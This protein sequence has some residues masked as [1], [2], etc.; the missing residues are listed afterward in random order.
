[1]LPE[2]ELPAQRASQPLRAQRPWDAQPAPQAVELQEQLPPAVQPQ[3]EAW[4]LS[5]QW[6]ASPGA[7]EP[8]GASEALQQLPSSG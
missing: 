4:L 5:A 8:R 3:P 7:E 1:V 6:A 2:Q